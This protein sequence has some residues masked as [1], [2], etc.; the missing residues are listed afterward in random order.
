LFRVIAILETRVWR[1]FWVD[2]ADCV[3][4]LGGAIIGMHAA[5]LVGAAIAFLVSSVVIAVGVTPAALLGLRRISAR[6]VPTLA[7]E[8]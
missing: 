5:G 6:A 8:I 7:S 4:F 2:L 3:I 1:I